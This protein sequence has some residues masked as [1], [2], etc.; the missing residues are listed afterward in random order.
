MQFNF[1][2]LQLNQRFSDSIDDLMTQHLTE[3]TIKL[4]YKTL[5]KYLLN[6]N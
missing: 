3:S 1:F 4:V 5:D 2:Q 6:I